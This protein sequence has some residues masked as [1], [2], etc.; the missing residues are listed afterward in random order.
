MAPRCSPLLGLAEGL[1]AGAHARRGYDGRL[2]SRV[3]GRH[4]VLVGLSAPSEACIYRD[5]VLV[6]RQEG[7]S[8]RP[9]PVSISGARSHGPSV[10]CRS[11][12]VLRHRVS[13]GGLFIAATEMASCVQQA[14]S[15]GCTSRA[16]TSCLARWTCTWRWPRRDLS[17]GVRDV[18]AGLGE[19][20]QR[21]GCVAVAALLAEWRTS[22]SCV[23]ARLHL[24]S[25]EP[26]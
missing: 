2:P 9:L 3:V 17:I 10:G 26:A 19:R 15:A 18:D 22:G 21:A 6:F 13:P 7:T 23:T 20:R 16:R 5:G 1:A 14:C 4:G 24:N 11:G 25:P 12:C 8:D